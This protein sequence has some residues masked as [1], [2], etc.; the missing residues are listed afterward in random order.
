MYQRI[1]T[2]YKK[3][4]IEIKSSLLFDLFLS[5]SFFLIIIISLLIKR[6]PQKVFTALISHIKMK[7]LCKHNHLSSHQ[8]SISRKN[9][10]FNISHQHSSNNHRLS[11]GQK[12]LTEEKKHFYPKHFTSRWNAFANTPSPL[13]SPKHLWGRKKKTFLS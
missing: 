6:I 3:N 13:F 10:I 2:K 1:D 12:Y 5:F 7:C 4:Q 8:R 11:S 9:Y